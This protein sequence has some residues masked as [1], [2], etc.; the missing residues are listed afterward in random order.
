MSN[1]MAIQYVRANIPRPDPATRQEIVDYYREHRSEFEIEARV[2]W[3]QIQCMYARPAARGEAEKKIRAARGELQR[4]QPFEAVARKYSE[5]PFA[6]TGGNWDW[7][8]PGSMADK[9]L[10]NRLFELPVGEVSGIFEG[11]DSFLV[12]EVLEREEA[13]VRKFA[14]VQNEIKDKIDKERQAEAPR[15]FLKKVWD[16]AVIESR[17]DLQGSPQQ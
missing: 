12:V 9:D 10:E 8:T 15:E 1:I 17:Y 13:G 16:S 14:E 7:I 4:G 5:D 2:R 11:K 3:R 6:K